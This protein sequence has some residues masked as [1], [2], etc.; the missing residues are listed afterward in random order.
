MSDSIEQAKQEVAELIAA[1]Y[2]VQAIRDVLMN[3]F[4]NAPLAGKL[5]YWVD[6]KNSMQKQKA[7]AASP[8]ATPPAND[9]PKGGTEGDFKYEAS[10]DDGGVI[11]SKYTGSGTEVQI[12]SQLGGKPVVGIGAE[13]FCGKQLTFVAIPASVKSIGR[14][15]FNDN[16]LALAVIPDG[17]IKIGDGAFGAFSNQRALVKKAS[18]YAYE[19]ANPQY[20]TPEDIKWEKTKDGK[21]VIIRR[22]EGK[23]KELTELNIPPQI[24]GLPVIE[25]GAYFV[26]K[27][28]PWG[29]P[30]LS[31]VIIPDS[32]ITIGSSFQDCGEIASLIIGK[33]VKTIG[34]HAFSGNKLTEVVIP[35]GVTS[36]ENSA[37]SRNQLTSVTIPDSVTSIWKFAFAKNQLTSIT[38][39]PNVTVIS[40]SVFADNKLTS[41]A[42]P[43]GVTKIEGN[44]FSGNELASITIPDSV[45]HIGRHAFQNNKLK[46]VIIPGGVIEIEQDAFAVCPLVS[47][48]I[49][50]NVSLP[51]LEIIDSIVNG[52]VFESGFAELYRKNR[53]K[54]TAAGTYTRPN[55]ASDWAKE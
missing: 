51:N 33:G 40:D 52:K 45:T 38:T 55:A 27:G 44:A 35:D 23:N 16:P 29:L 7:D 1:Q 15:A 13:A 50:G 42:M 26:K 43:H 39:P 36:I 22:Y 47:F 11:I 41:V 14:R 3:N 32:V 18:H 53:H 8:P 19:T 4:Q 6:I 28:G 9:Q 54:G 2:P 20:L 25:I 10:E 37:F 48:T 12:P 30:K 46:S 49:G 17:E 24:Q 21:A 5:E 31:S 34:S